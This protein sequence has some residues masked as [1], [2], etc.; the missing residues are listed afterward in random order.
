MFSSGIDKS[1]H[2][3]SSDGCQCSLKFNT[4]TAFE[5]TD[6][7]MNDKV[8]HAELSQVRGWGGRGGRVSIPF[9]P[10]THVTGQ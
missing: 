4:N 2:K 3:T 7:S 5:Y 6:L 1:L 10:F 9:F 8:V